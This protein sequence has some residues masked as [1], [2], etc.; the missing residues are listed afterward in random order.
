MGGESDF[1]KGLI[2]AQDLA[3]SAPEHTT[4]FIG[5]TDGCKADAQTSVQDCEAALN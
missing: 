5:F 2:A 4:V 3:K 1:S